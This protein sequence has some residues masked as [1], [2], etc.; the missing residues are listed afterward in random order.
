[1]RNFVLLLLV[2]G[3]AFAVNNKQL[4]G[5]KRLMK[6]LP[7]GIFPTCSIV[8]FSDVVDYDTAEA[9]CKSFDLGTGTLGEGNLV[10]VDDPVKNEDMKFLL[11]LAYP[12]KETYGKW[13]NT[14]WAWAGLRKTS[15]TAP[16]SKKDKTYNLF[17][18][19]WADKSNPSGY[20][21]WMRKQPDQSSL[22]NG[23]KGCN[24]VP[25]CFQNQMRVNHHGA[26]DDTFKFKEHPFA[27]DYQGKYLISPELKTWESARQACVDA[28]LILAKVRS[29]KEMDAIVG[30]AE[31]ILGPVNS[32]E[33]IFHY[34]NWFWIGGNDVDEEG[35]WQWADGERIFDWGFPWRS[36]NPDN[37]GYALASGQNAMSV[38]KWG[39]VDDS[40]QVKRKRPFACQCPGT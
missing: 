6:G 40:F 36:P 4:N 9:K 15:N 12:L 34:S 8:F 33:K 22:K 20:V 25:Q 27:C 7:Q 21:K 35:I 28:G 32:D 30:I 14:S 10:T 23:K 18:W 11:E 1:M 17:D 16:A 5:L 38:S 31:F 2:L 29:Q 37:A 3:L 13:S 39:Q 19:Q 24:E 26:W